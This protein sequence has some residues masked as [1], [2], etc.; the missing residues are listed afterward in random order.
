MT[1]DTQPPSGIKRKQDDD[2]ALARNED[3]PSD[4]RDAIAGPADELRPSVAPDSDIGD[5][6]ELTRRGYTSEVATGDRRP[7][8]AAEPGTPTITRDPSMSRAVDVAAAGVDPAALG[9]GDVN[10]EIG[11]PGPLAP[12][13]EEQ[14]PQAEGEPAGKYGSS[15]S[16]TG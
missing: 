6:A 5:G 13:A 12:T 9:Y 1:K 3:A 11:H 8:Q 10:G 2:A 15:G 16:P 7:W 4:L 14:S